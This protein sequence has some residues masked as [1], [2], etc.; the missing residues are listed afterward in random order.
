MATSLTL[1]T[2]LP[3]RAFLTLPAV[4]VPDWNYSLF[5]EVSTQINQ[6]DEATDGSQVNACILWE[7]VPEKP[8]KV[9]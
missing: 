8:A 7:P 9:C 2:C 5:R 4:Y 1:T 3:L 6:R